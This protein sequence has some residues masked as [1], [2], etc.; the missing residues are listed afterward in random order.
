MF[1]S[2]VVDERELGSEDGL[3]LGGAVRRKNLFIV[4]S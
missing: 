3:L 1:R 4:E 2:S